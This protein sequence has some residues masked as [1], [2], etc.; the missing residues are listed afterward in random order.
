[1]RNALDCGRTGADDADALVLQLA[2][3]AVAVTTGITIVP[4]A[5]VKGVALEIVDARYR[6]ELRPAERSIGHRYV[7][8]LEAVATVGGDDPALIAFVPAQVGDR[9]LHQ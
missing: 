6:R 2:Q 3:V 1:M 4:S 9:R 8:R 7:L 5:G